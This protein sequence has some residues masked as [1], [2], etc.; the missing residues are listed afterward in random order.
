MDDFRFWLKLVNSDDRLEIRKKIGWGG[1]G[2]FGLNLIQA[3]RESL[4]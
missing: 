2:G 1:G 4:K 3:H